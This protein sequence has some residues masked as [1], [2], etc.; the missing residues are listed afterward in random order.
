M[1]KVDMDRKAGGA[2]VIE[3]RGDL[4]EIYSDI[5][6]TLNAIH[7]QLRQS[8]PV[9]AEIFKSA[10]VEAISHPKSPV[11]EPQGDMHGLIFSIPNK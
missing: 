5:A 11:W 1:L 7:T 2:A 9:L 3:A 6:H 8:E 10:F 4:I